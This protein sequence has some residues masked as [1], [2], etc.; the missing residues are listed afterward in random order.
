MSILVSVVVPTCRRPQLLD[1]CLQALVTQNFPPN[2][3]EIIIVDDG[4]EDQATLNLVADWQ[5]RLQACYQ[6]AAPPLFA[7]IPVS[8]MPASSSTALAYQ[9]KAGPESFPR[10]HYIP[11][12]RSRG[13]AAARNT[14]WHFA[15]GE[16]IAYTDDDC[17]PDPDWLAAGLSAFSAEVA[18]VSGRV[19]VPLPA[20]P[21]DNDRNTTGLERSLFVTANCFYRR[22]ALEAVGGFDQRFRIAWREDSDLFFTLMDQG[23]Q[24]IKSDDALVVHP[25]RPVRW[26]SSIGQQRKSFYNALLYKKHPDKYRD[27]IQPGPPYRY[28]AMLLAFLIGLAG[29]FINMPLL[30]AGGLGLWLGLIAHFTIGRIRNTSK[31]PAH[32]ADMVFSSLIIPFLSL[33]WRLR[34]ALHWRVWFF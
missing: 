4:P 8:G 26:G 30:A 5:R 1:R 22:E 2:N 3:F 31:A 18:G 11:A 23:Y 27:Y 28:Y 33:Y 20:N 9:V 32:L 13:P 14:G 15:A 34:G 29:L 12:L 6:Y 7:S 21:T 17:I 24:L 25:V 10:L 16:I 19:I